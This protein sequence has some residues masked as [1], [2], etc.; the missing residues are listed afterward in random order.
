M[1]TRRLVL[2]MPG[3]A[4]ARGNKP[5]RLYRRAGEL[6]DLSREEAGAQLRQALRKDPGDAVS[7]F[8]LGLLAAEALEQDPDGL[9][10]EMTPLVTGPAV[11]PLQEPSD[12]AAL[13]ELQAWLSDHTGATEKAAQLRT[14]ALEIRQGIVRQLFPV[15][16]TADEHPPKPDK[17]VT[18][19][20]LTR[21]REPGYSPLARFARWQ[22]VVVLVITVAADGKPR[23]I[24]FLRGLGLGLDECAVAAVRTWRFEPAQ[25]HGKP[26][27]SP[28]TIEVNFR[29]L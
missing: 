10:R 14:R 11:A 15:E 5:T 22:G 21:K 12:L 18:L 4:L 7:R 6:D 1:V 8:L 3:L 26:I 20:K 28:A 2:T 13:L 19:P 24:R 25:H 16:T 29:L 27:D 9:T 17:G 23:Q